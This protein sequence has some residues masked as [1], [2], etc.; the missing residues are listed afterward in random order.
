M[1]LQ[2]VT[3]SSGSGKSRKVYQEMIER[4]LAHP[5]QYYVVLV[6]EQASLITQQQ[7]IELH[8]QHS[9]SRI[10]VLSFT[11]LAYRVFEE[12]QID[13]GK[14][15]DETGKTM[16]LR[17]VVEQQRGELHYFGGMLDRVGFAG[18]LKSV[19]SEFLQCG[20]SA[21]VLEALQ[22]KSKELPAGQVMLSH[23]LEDLAC[24]SK[25]FQEA[26]SKEYTTVE[27]RTVLLAKHLH[28]S[29][30]LKRTEMVVEGFTGFTPIQY[31]VLEELLCLVP[32]LQM[33][34]TVRPGEEK[35]QAEHAL[36]AMSHTIRTHLERMAAEH[37][38]PVMPDER[39]TGACPR[40]AKAPDLAALET[41]FDA[42]PCPVYEA[43]PEHLSLLCMKNPEEEVRYVLQQI[44]TLVRSGYCYRDIAVITGDPAAY[45][46][47]VRNYFEKV[48]LPIFVDEKS[49]M[50]GSPLVH[51]IVAALQVAEENFSYESVFRFLKSGL[52]P[53]EAGQLDALENY[54]LALGIRGKSAWQKTWEKRYRGLSEN[55]LPTYNGLREQIA[56]WLVPFVTEMREKDKTTLER[57]ACLR[58]LLGQL[59][60]KEQLETYSVQFAEAGDFLRE[61]EYRQCW[62]SVDALLQQYELLMGE[63]VL[64]Y[65]EFQ[66]ILESGLQELA[67]G[68]LPTTLDRLVIGDLK[69]T[70]LGAVR[71]LFILGANEG[72]IPA[73]TKESG[74]LSDRDREFF[75]S[76]E[77]ELTATSREDAFHQRYYLYLALSKASEQLTISCANTDSDGKQLRPSELYSDLKRIFPKTVIH[78]VESDG[79][80]TPEIAFSK[81][82][83]GLRDWRD[84]VRTEE[85]VQQFPELYAWYAHQ[86]DW[87]KRL[88]QLLDGAFYT[89]Q[90]EKLSERTSELI[91]GEH[92]VN[93]VS[94]LETFASCAYA[95]F[96]TY[97]LELQPR[98]K[99]EL[100]AADFG[101]VYHQAL[102]KFFHQMFEQ[103]LSFAEMTPEVQHE[104]AETSV[105]KATE[106]YSNTIF[107]SSAR[108]KYL[109]EQI[110]AVT[111]R[112]VWALGQQLSLGRFEP[113]GSEQVF[114]AQ[115]HLESMQ[116][117]LKDGRKVE[118]AGRIDR[119]D[120]A[121][122]DEKVYVK[123]IDYKTGSTTFDYTRLYYGLQ[124]QLALYMGAAL[125]LVARRYPEKQVIP[126]GIFYYKIQD[127]LIDTEGEA[128]GC[129]G[130]RLKELRMNGLVEGSA[131]TLRQFETEHGKQSAVIQGVTYEDSGAAT[132]KSQAASE[133]QMAQL[134]RYAKKKAARLGES[135]Y[136]GNIAV[137]PYEYKTRTSCDWC[138]YQAVCGFEKGLSGYQKR[139]LTELKPDTFWQ[140]LEKYE[141]EEGK[142]E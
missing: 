49:S 1:S 76:Q 108:N 135:L 118:L 109:V 84:G 33:V 58:Q 136:E 10:E 69:R 46:P 67:V 14:V 30:R 132:A 59:G 50:S 92:P 32:R 21:E 126:A 90:K 7:L 2:F 36:F 133:R 124:L 104:L 62:D 103:K 63:E 65:A 130:A 41:G 73:A 20:V 140:V 105:R 25:G 94:R 47:W 64:S 75:Q 85:F 57:I 45:A 131:Q 39:L 102:D 53:I 141:E 97:G 122:E 93:S 5:E 55:F 44:L 129:D 34:L 71:A 98:Q 9:L 74:I 3:G 119:I 13:P 91:Y 88:L 42:W 79:I 106:N 112:T 40:F 18:E 11:R 37:Q 89:Y 87:E 70:R 27:E 134:L 77:V 35:E 95:H 52:V 82:A 8:P 116:L 117:Y 4:S 120:L 28:R 83:S 101:T 138:P 115:D 68:V 96:L 137:N 121:F 78:Q 72:L 17:K 22:Q 6:P 81:L 128:D 125:E 61:M 142:E 54:V 139:R 19:I 12:L 107:E 51:L 26:L 111:D 31:Q 56:G 99:Y 113:E 110:L 86:G 43:V 127:P 29:D 80:L 100:Q 48:G 66:E 114:T 24:I 15:L 16:I 38:I 60:V 23:K 123:I